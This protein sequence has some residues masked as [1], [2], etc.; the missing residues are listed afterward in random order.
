MKLNEAVGNP[1]M[2][3]ETAGIDAPAQSP[4]FVLRVTAGVHRGAVIRLGAAGNL[5]IGASDDCDVI[6][7]D[8]G[9]AGH[10]CI[11]RKRDSAF[12]LRAIEGATTVDGHPLDTGTTIGIRAGATIAIGSAS[13]EIGGTS[14]PAR[15]ATQVT[16][17]PVPAPAPVAAVSTALDRIAPVIASGPAIEQMF[18][19]DDPVAGLLLKSGLSAWLVAAALVAIVLAAVLL[20]VEFRGRTAQTAATPE[21]LLREPVASR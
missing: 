10:H 5:V 7:A 3:E 6:L 17:A 4:M 14:S 9:V 1:I 19:K 20:T 18:A 8:R 11:L 12:L 16:S 13:L 15:P 2:D 21:I